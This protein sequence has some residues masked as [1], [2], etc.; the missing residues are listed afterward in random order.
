MQRLGFLLLYPVIWLISIL[1]FRLL[2]ALSDVIYVIVYHVLGYRKTIVLEH[3]QM[4]FPQKSEKELL[5]I[6][7]KFYKHF[8]DIFLEMIK[9]LSISNKALKKRFVIKNPQEIKRLESLNKS[10]I[11]MLGHYASYEWIVAL[12]FYGMTYKTYGAYKKIK[13]KYFDRL[14]KKIRGRYNATLLNAK[15]VAKTMVQNN[16]KNELGSYGMIADQAPKA[17]KSK[18]QRYFMGKKVPVFVGSESL[19][20]RL[21]FAVTYLHIEKVKRGYYEASFIPLA[22]NPKEYP[23]YAITDKFFEYLEKQINKKPEFYLWT[24]KRWKHSLN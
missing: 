11:I 10:Y 1:P 7:K 19:A 8:C 15:T 23:D 5:Q 2:Y 20:K 6:R 9:T 4:A 16:F 14:I 12:P 3:L 13:N 18:Y 22:D 21:N 24:H 17:G